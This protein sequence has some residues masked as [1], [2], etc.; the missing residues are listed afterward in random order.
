MPA[1]MEKPQPASYESP[2]L[3]LAAAHELDESE[4]AWFAALAWALLTYGSAWAFC[5]SVCGWNRVSSCS[6]NWFGRVK[7]VCR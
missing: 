7:A 1:T 3:N 2:A 6:T 5:R 4:L